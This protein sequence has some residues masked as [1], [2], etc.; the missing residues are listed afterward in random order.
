MKAFVITIRD[1]EYSESC[2]DRC[3]RSAN[4]YG[5][6]V[7]KFYGVDKHNAYVYLDDYQLVWG[8]AENNTKV[9]ICEHTG[10]HQFPYNT[11]DLRSKIACSLSHFLLWKKCIDL[12]EP[13]L[14]LEH[15]AVFIREL[16]EI[17][18]HGAIQINNPTGGGY[19]GKWHSNFMTK[20]STIGV[21]PLTRKREETSIIPDGFSGGSAYIIKPW[22]AK[23]FVSAF[24]KYGVWPND[25]TICLQLFPWLEEYYPF[26][27]QIEQTQSTSK[28]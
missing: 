1:H 11:K 9:K 10:L 2:A 14:I 8:W 19:K 16:P 7:E 4:R 5:I 28:Q 21:H 26:I 15:D 22:A 3:I 17:E 20:R 18:F 27:T 24:H 12:N 25:A 13:I 23:E 6:K